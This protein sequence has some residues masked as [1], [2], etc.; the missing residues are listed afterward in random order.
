MKRLL[1]RRILLG[2]GVLNFSLWATCLSAQPPGAPKGKGPKGPPGPPPDAEFR[3]VS[4]TVKEFTTAPKGEV[5][6]LLLTDGTWVHWPPHLQG[7]F[8]AIVAKGDRIRVA[9]SWETG[10]AGDTKLEVS[11]LTNVVSGKTSTN[12]DRPPA[13]LA[14]RRPASAGEIDE[15]LQALEDRLDKLEAAVERLPRRR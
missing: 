13:R 8:T 11:T 1:P 14:R 10:P 15:R 4:G 3:T 5:D 6:G 9:G 7:R 12:P 2:L